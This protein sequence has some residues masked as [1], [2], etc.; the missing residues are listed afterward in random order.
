MADDDKTCSHHQPHRHKDYAGRVEATE[1]ERIA[2]TAAKLAT[3]EALNELL[4]LFGVARERRIRGE[5]QVGL[6]V[7]FRNFARA[8]KAKC[9]FYLTIVALFAGAF[10]YGIV[11]WLKTV[12]IKNG[13]AGAAGC[14]PRW[15]RL[16]GLFLFRGVG[17]ASHKRGRAM[18]DPAGDGSPGGWPG[19]LTVSALPAFLLPG[20]NLP[21][22]AYHHSGFR[23]P[24]AP[25]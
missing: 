17:P 4:A 16:A 14:V 21:A 18:P 11:S 20:F 9:R 24:P 8:L 6:V 19:L 2:V 12:F 25:P 13:Y 7:S 15:R 22:C 10:A 5:A 1:L 23:L 3:N